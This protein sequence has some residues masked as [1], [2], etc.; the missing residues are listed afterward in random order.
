VFAE[1]GVNEEQL[2]EA[3][4]LVAQAA[5]HTGDTCQGVVDLTLAVNLLIG[6]VEGHRH[7]LASGEVATSGFYTGPMQAMEGR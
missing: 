7:A 4:R 6:L 3:K 1:A 5:S 2:R